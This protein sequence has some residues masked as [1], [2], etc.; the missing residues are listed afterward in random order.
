MAGFVAMLDRAG[1]LL[2]VGEPA[3]QR[4]G[5]IRE[6]VI[7][8]VKRPV[9]EDVALD[10]PQHAERRQQVVRGRDLVSLAPDVVRREPADRAH[11][12]CVVADGDVVVAALVGRPGHI[13]D[14]RL[15]VRPPRMAVEVD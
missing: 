10:P 9:R 6:D 1:I 11:S 3:V 14:G 2:E 13:R 8:K 15:A 7:G 5:L 4:G 12:G